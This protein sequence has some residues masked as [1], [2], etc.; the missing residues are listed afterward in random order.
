[1][2]FQCEVAIIYNE[3]SEERKT[4]K[5]NILDD[6]SRVLQRLG[7]F[8]IIKLIFDNIEDKN[9]LDDVKNTILHYAA[10]KGHLEICK[11]IVSRVE[12]KNLA[13]NSK[14]IYNGTPL[15]RARYYNQQQIVDYLTSQI[16]N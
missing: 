2:Y 6:N 14:N 9:P 1:M 4:L 7:H 5:Q 13:L 15:E 8:E 16:K 12:D 3:E 10:Q 11:Y